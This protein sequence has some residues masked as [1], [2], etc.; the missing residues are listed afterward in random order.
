MKRAISKRIGAAA[1]ALLLC[2]L[3][4]A[5]ASAF[6]AGFDEVKD[7]PCSL[8]VD[9]ALDDGPMGGVEFQLWRVADISGRGYTPL[10]DIWSYHV[11]LGSGNWLVK[12]N[13]LYGYLLRD[14]VAADYRART[15]A[16]GT[17]RFEGLERGL[18]L[19]VGAERTRGDYIYRPTPFLISL[20]HTQ[21]L[22]S[23][24]TDVKTYSKHTRSAVV[25][26][27]P[28]PP[29]PDTPD[30]PAPETISRHVLKVWD[31]EG[32]EDQRPEQVIVDLLRDG[33]VYDTAVLTAAGSWRHDWTGLEADRDWRVVERELEDYSVETAQE[34]ITFVVTNTWREETDIGGDDP[35]LDDDPDLPPDDPGREDPPEE[36]I[37]DNDP[38]LDDQPDL[39]DD[40]TGDPGDGP[41]DD[42]GEDPG[43]DPGGT[44][45]GGE[46]LPQTG[47]L[48]WPVPLLAMGG[49]VL[50]LIG[51]VRRR[52]WSAE[53]E[54]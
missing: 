24:T 42:P 34:G 33:E 10:E 36:Q 12:A 7:V 53:D 2:A 15:D 44:P 19:V 48:W 5:P 46:K 38:P 17:V 22:Y 28:T 4:L 50:L 30:D 47:L 3:C 45:G 51:W 16:K 27:T 14:G 8:T 52:R 11:L 31:D 18:Y 26:P 32:F 21:D 35:P 9:Y 41:G 13:T 25:H 39:T 1:L 20:P 6:A 49:V 29:G 54:G 23:W 40:P 43:E 37:W